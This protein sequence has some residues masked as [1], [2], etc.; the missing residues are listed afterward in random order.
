MEPNVDQVQLNS[1]VTNVPLNSTTNTT[2][3]ISKN[4]ESLWYTVMDKSAL[5]M[6]IVGIIANLLTTVVLRRHQ[7]K[8][9]SPLIRILLQVSHYKSAQYLRLIKRSRQPYS[10]AK[11]YLGYDLAHINRSQTVPRYGL[12]Y[13]II[14]NPGP[15]F[16]LAIYVYP[17]YN[18]VMICVHQIILGNVKIGYGLA[19]TPGDEARDVIIKVIH[20]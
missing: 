10:P 13:K 4:K 6:L 12:A 8:V 20:G 11:L 5:V 19:A 2:E 7:G 9:F 15:G 16:C 17:G 14:A 18:F 3:T 1:N